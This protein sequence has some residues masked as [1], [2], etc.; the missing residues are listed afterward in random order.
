MSPESQFEDLTQKR[1]ELPDAHVQALKT[2]LDR[3]PPEKFDWVLTGSASLRLQGVDVTVHDLDIECN[4]QVIR[5]IEQ[6][7]SEYITTPVHLWESGRIRSLDG[8]AQIDGVEIEIISE[9]EAL[10]PDGSWERLIDFDQK[11]WLEWQGLQVPLLPLA[12]EAVAYAEMGRDEKALLI[13]ETIQRM[14]EIRHT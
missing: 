2:L 3:I 4:S 13:R 14:K 8:K 7:L 6:A 12:A 10:R 5:K 11:F 9:L 1:F